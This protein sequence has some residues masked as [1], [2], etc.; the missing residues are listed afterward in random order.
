MLP[1]NEPVTAEH[2]KTRGVKQHGASQLF[3][4]KEPLLFRNLFS[5]SALLSLH[6]VSI[7]H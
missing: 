5:Q 3:S 6:H 2:Q 1:M 4:V 7:M